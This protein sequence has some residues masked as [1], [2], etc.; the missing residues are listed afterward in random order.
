MKQTAVE[1][2]VEQYLKRK[3]FLKTSDI[4][5]ALEM[6]KEHIRVAY[7]EGAF[8]KMRHLNGKEFILPEQYYNTTFKS[9]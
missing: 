6:E 5:Q 1:W 2:L 7:M 4:E 3:G 9:E 8:E